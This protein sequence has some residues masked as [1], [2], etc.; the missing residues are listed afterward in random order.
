VEEL[1]EKTWIT[2][3]ATRRLTFYKNIEE[4]WKEALFDL[5]GEY[6]QMI[7]YPRDPQLN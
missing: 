1:S 7:N 4:I 2:R 3:N 5:G 6:Q